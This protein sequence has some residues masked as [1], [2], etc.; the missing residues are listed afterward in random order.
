MGR[1]CIGETT[2]HKMVNKG[3]IRVFKIGNKTL[4]TEAEIQR[5]MAGQL[6]EPSKRALAAS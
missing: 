1:L 2:F 5:I 3:Q 4:V 6:D